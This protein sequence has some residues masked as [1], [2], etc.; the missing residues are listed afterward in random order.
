MRADRPRIGIDLGGTKIEGIVL[1]GDGEILERLRRPTPQDNYEATL[2]TVCD[3]VRDL[4]SDYGELP[5][6]IG[7]PGSVSPATGRISAGRIRHD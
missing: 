7:T 3:L 4:E 6:G 2:D 1:N 5:L